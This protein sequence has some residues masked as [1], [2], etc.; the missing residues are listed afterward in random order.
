MEYPKTKR[1]VLKHVGNIPHLDLHYST[2]NYYWYFTYDNGAEIFETHIVMVMHLKDLKLESWAEEV[3][4]F[5][6]KIGVQN[7]N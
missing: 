7:V 2:G 5:L 4:F 6:E 3:K 1:D